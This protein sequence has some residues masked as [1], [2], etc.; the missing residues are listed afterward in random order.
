MHPTLTPHLD[1]AL[2]G[3]YAF[4]LFFLGLVFYLRRED[5]REGY[6]LEDDLTGRVQSSGGAMHTAP[7]KSFRLPFGH[8][9]V[10]A[11][12]GGR[13]PFRLAARKTENFHGAPL[14]PT[15]DPLV[16]GIGPAAYA[17][18]ARRPDLDMEGHPRIVPIGLADITIA[19][20]DPDPRGMAVVGMDG[21]VAG[22]V[23]DLWVD[24][25][26]RLI[27]YL[28]VAL[29]G[30]T[31]RQ[32]LVPMAMLKID[33]RRGR[34]IVDAIRASQF[35]NAPVIAAADHITLYEEERVVGY[36]GGGYLY[37]TPAR[38]EPWL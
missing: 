4:F 17:E 30:A 19:P 21:V 31:G 25:A 12:T 34:V 10:T 9:I 8:G 14:V 35:A 18:R 1:V 2:R 26:D 7:T 5:R 32:V 15:G 20:K 3:L 11:P 24:K 16:D 23:S 36:F 22:T 38:S 37:A 6:P 13:D 27:R 29:D 28:Q 33:R